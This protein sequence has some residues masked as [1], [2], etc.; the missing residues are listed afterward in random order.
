MY[1]NFQGTGGVI[2]PIQMKSYLPIC[3]FTSP[4]HEIIILNISFTYILLLMYVKFYF[5]QT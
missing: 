3:S 4:I 1:I 2:L 5:C